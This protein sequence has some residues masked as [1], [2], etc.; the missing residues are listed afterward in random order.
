[1]PIRTSALTLLVPKRLRIYTSDSATILWHLFRSYLCVVFVH[2]QR[3][4]YIKGSCRKTYQGSITH[5]PRPLLTETS[6]TANTFA[7]TLTHVRQDTKR[8]HLLCNLP[9]G[10]SLVR[11]CFPCYNLFVF[12]FPVHILPC[13]VFCCSCLNFP[14][15]TTRRKPGAGGDLP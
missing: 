14:A 8:E 13:H 5:H 4:A 1:M 6:R 3:I 15:R 2:F 12:L 9:N 10:N 7:V 11:I